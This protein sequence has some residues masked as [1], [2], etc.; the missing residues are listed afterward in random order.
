MR[1]CA[2]PILLA[3]VAASPAPTVEVANGNW[4]GLPPLQHVS[5]SHLSLSIMSKLYEIGR[6]QKC[7]LPGQTGNRIDMSISFAAQFTP[8]GK[9]TRLLLP[10]LNCPQ[11]ESWLGGT[12]VQAIEKGDYRPNPQEPNDHGWYRGEFNFYYE[13]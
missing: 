4:S 11:A 6:Q 8:E 3:L 5:Y 7:Q 2:A 10:E 12:L 9:L 13:G 1:I